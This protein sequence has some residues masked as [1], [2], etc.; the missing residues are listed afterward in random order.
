M[1]SQL[2]LH[3]DYNQYILKADILNHRQAVR[4]P[5]YKTLKIGVLGVQFAKEI[6]FCF[7]NYF[8][9]PPRSS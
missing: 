1:L 4:P 3:Q 5:T 2:S 8:K 7:M 6:K 9:L